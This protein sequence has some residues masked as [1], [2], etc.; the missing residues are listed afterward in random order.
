VTPLNFSTARSS[1]RFVKSKVE[2]PFSYIRQDFFV[3]RSFRN[4]DDLNA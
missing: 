2:R 4:L 3:G 1:T